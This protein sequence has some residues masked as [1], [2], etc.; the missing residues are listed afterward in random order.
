MSSSVTRTETSFAPECRLPHSRWAV[1]VL[2]AIVEVIALTTYFDTGDL[3]TNAAWS[4]TLLMKARALG[5]PGIVVVLA[6][7]CFAAG[8]M[9]AALLDHAGAIRERRIWPYLLAHFGA[10]A[11]FAWLS[12]QITGG[13]SV[14][15][16]AHWAIFLWLVS[17]VLALYFWV[18]ALL[19]WKFVG[20]LIG[21]IWKQI[22]C[23]IAAGGLAMAAGH[24][25]IGLWETFH[26]STFQMVS[27]VLGL[28]S[29]DLICE[30]ANFIVGLRGFSVRI[31][32]ACSGYEGIG[33]I[34]VFLCGYLL[35]FRN[36]LRFPSA[37][38]LLPVGT[39]V[40]WFANV[41]RIV[42]LVMIGASGHP[43]LALGGFHSQSG[44]LAF[45]AVGLGLVLASRR[46]QFFRRDPHATDAGE[47]CNPTTAYIAPLLI[48]VATT[49]V[50]TAISSSNFDFLYPARVVATLIVLCWFRRNYRAIGWSWSWSW[51]ALAVG[52]VVFA[53]WLALEPATASPS[54]TGTV[55]SALRAMS[56][57]AAISW[58]VF[59]IFGSVVTVPIAEE[60]AFRGY[61]S[62]RLVSS[63]FESIPGRR[64]TWISILISS[65]FFGALHQ[66]WMAGTVAGILYA[67]VYYRR[68]RLSDAILA[69]ATT[70]AMI[71]LQVT[72]FNDWHLWN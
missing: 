13:W 55:P 71:A 54:R 40:I 37:L 2:V 38:L 20:L 56:P 21:T 30:P 4:V 46:L 31:E 44:W 7:F 48:L 45:N 19:P 47:S 1:L 34:W 70:N 59:R 5:R 8:A 18:E 60:L 28:V 36:E 67:A 12:Q 69:H 58:V 29:R 15:E 16:F 22:L 24:L 3:P 25:T 10:T 23:G 17:G 6:T 26:R 65:L 66:R 39:V 11:L 33:L 27:A 63:D 50:S 62:R 35:L 61:L 43:K 32:P 52:G 72:I 9:R 64:Q 42:A 53:I 68:G 41:L 57:I 51:L 49:M 14:T